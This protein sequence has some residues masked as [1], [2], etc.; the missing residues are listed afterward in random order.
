MESITRRDFL[1][2]SSIA[3]ASPLEAPK[4]ITNE[5]N[6][7]FVTYFWRNGE[8]IVIAQGFKTPLGPVL[9]C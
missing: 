5:L 7:A 9:Y 6:G 4:I 8:M 2:Y 3:L 1:K